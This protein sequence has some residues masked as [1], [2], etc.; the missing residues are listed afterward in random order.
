MSSTV[1][2]IRVIPRAP[3][4]RV[5]GTRAGAILIRLAAPPVDGAANDALVAFLAAALALPRRNIRIVS[6]EKSRDKRVEIDGLDT[7]A[8]LDR[9]LR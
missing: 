4:T 9:L 2:D 5:D 6:G 7:Q 3:R 8:A 1:L